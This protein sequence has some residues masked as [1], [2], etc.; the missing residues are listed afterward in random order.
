MLISFSVFSVHIRIHFF[1]FSDVSQNSP[2]GNRVVE[3]ELTD[4]GFEYV[5][6]FV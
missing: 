5:S 6:Y 4:P 2:L 3:I 1:F